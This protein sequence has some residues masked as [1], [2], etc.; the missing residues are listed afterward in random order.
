MFFTLQ[1]YSE[2]LAKELVEKIAALNV[3]TIQGEGTFEVVATTEGVDRD[4]E[5]I[6][7]N[8]WD[9]TNFQKNPVLLMSHDWRSLPVGAVTEIVPDYNAKKII[10]RGVFAST[11]A[12]QELRKLYDDGIM[13]TVSVGFIAKERN[14]NT[15]SKAELLELSFVSV[16]SNPDAISLSRMVKFSKMI[17]EGQP[18]EEGTK[19]A[20]IPEGAAMLENL[21]KLI[22]DMSAIY[23]H[24]EVSLSGTKAIVV[25]EKAGRVLSSKNRDLVQQCCDML[26]QLLEATDPQASDPAS[27]DAAK[28]LIMDAQ[29]MQKM[30]ENVIKKAKIVV[31]D[32]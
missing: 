23:R 8:G 29:S 18:V 13:R 25:E 6:L 9:F 14:G 12:G 15:I 10:M 3:K 11:P 27:T 4:G 19:N 2:K 16:P 21:G 5:V 24:Y 28:T 22:K 7:V 1:E 31:K 17:E 32:T 20:D 26:T 30:L